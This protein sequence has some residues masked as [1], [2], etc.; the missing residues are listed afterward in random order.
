MQIIYFYIYKVFER[1][2]RWLLLKT[3]V[4][5][6]GLAWEMQKNFTY[7]LEVSLLVVIKEITNFYMEFVVDVP[8]VPA[9]TILLKYSITSLLFW[10]LALLARIRIHLCAS[11]FGF[12]RSARVS[13]RHSWNRATNSLGSFNWVWMPWRTSLRRARDFSRN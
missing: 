7:Y 9:G 13:R 1:V 3:G 8:V 10:D 5:F 4:F 2:M 12:S 11:G 6:C